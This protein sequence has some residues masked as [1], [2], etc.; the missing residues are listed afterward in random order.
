M[1]IKESVGKYHWYYKQVNRYLDLNL[2]IWKKQFEISLFSMLQHL[3]IY[4]T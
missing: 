1:F 2:L 4:L 3:F